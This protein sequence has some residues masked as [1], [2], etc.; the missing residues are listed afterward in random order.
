MN[1]YETLPDDL[2]LKPDGEGVEEAAF[3]RKALRLRKG[4]T[5][6][7]APCGAGRIAIHLA[8]AGSVVTGIDL[9]RS[10]TKRAAARFRK[11]RRRGR[12][13]PM[14][15]RDMDFAGEFDGIYSWL[16]SFGYFDEPGNMDVMSRYDR[17]LRKGG[18]LLVDQVNR[19]NVL[20]HFRPLKE[21]GSPRVRS[22]W[23]PKRERVESVYVGNAKGRKRL[24]RSSMR[25]Y[26]FGQTR[27]LFERVG[28]A[29]EGV[30]GSFTGGPYRRSS[31]RLIV[32][33]KKPK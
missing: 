10:F 18:R 33:G 30:Y 15:L 21:F 16:G 22:R 26:T 29:V 31:R 27:R 3:I 13:I 4:S 12:F 14:D 32:V 17:A 7:D 19:Q 6:L 2:W 1:W 28:L 24:G 20:R 5:V 25:L 23:D 11:E 8:H 9:R